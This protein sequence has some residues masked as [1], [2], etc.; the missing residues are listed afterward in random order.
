[1]WARYDHTAPVITCFQQG[2]YQWLLPLL[3]PLNSRGVK[4]APSL[5]VVLRPIRKQEGEDFVY[6]VKT[7][8][9]LDM[10]LKQARL[11]GMLSQRWTISHRQMINW[12]NLSSQTAQFI[13]NPTDQHLKNNLKESLAICQQNMIKTLPSFG[14]APKTNIQSERGSRSY[15]PATS[16]ARE[17]SNASGESNAASSTRSDLDNDWRNRPAAPAADADSDGYVIVSK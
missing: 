6:Q 12:Q 4:Q 13:E 1:M 3:N 8:L 9:D 14:R 17:W 15:M 7:V 5:V 11:C 2:S 16:S 10:A